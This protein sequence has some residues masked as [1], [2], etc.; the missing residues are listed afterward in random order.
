MAKLNNPLVSL[1]AWGRIARDYAVRRHG[2]GHVLELRTPPKDAK[3]SAQLAWRTMYQLAVSLWAG[4]SGTEKE[5]WETNARPYHMTGFNYFMSQALKPNPGIYLPLAG[6]AM[7]GAIDMATNK[8]ENLPA[9]TAN[10]EPTRKADLATH[11]ALKTG[12]HGLSGSLTF[13][14]WQTA[15]QSIADATT[16]LLTIN[17]EDWDIG[18]C[19]NTGT[20]RHTP[21][22][23]GIYCYLANV[24]IP[25][26]GDAVY[27]NS[28][29]Y[30]NGLMH[31]RGFSF[32]PGASGY[33]QAPISA[34]VYMNGSTDYLDLRVYH[35]HGSA[36]DTGA[37]REE[38]W[39]CGF[40]ISQGGY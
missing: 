32:K 34:L 23:E 9:P 27:L 29:F 36:R 40:L 24:R 1:S 21:N 30:R 39:F 22:V 14:A 19:F 11:A 3:T 16:T 35:S 15:N 33:Y 5:A 13:Y 6:G 17:S 4:L 8:I 18:S 20:Y 2:G 37:G 12:V 7:S 38:T 31:R 26:L 25:S 28:Y 10:E